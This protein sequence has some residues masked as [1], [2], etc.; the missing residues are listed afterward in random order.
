MKTARVSLTISQDLVDD[1]RAQVG[2]GDL[3]AYIAMGIER[4]LRRD[5]LAQFLD[6][7]DSK[8]GPVPEAI[9]EEVWRE[10]R[11]EA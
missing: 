2:D 9:I 7:L 3:S 4:R 5:R 8:F 10:W 6:E 1:V 11:D